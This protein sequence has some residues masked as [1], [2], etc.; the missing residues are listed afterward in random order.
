MSPVV[1][2]VDLI[3]R[4]R[5][6]VRAKVGATRKS[7]TGRGHNLL[8]LANLP[9][10]VTHLPELPR[11]RQNQQVEFPGV[12]LHLLLQGEKN[13]VRDQHGFRIAPSLLAVT[14]VA[15]QLTPDGDDYLVGD[16]SAENRRGFVERLEIEPVEATKCSCR[17]ASRPSRF[18]R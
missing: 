6:K 12:A 17:T 16:Q 9:R 3:G 5:D 7:S 13:R 8:P 1:G 15:I 11:C 4:H 10:I 2:Q 18:R 14:P